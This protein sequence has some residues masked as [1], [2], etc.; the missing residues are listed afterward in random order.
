MVDCKGA[1][2]NKP[3]DNITTHLNVQT[4]YKYISINLYA[5]SHS[6]LKGEHCVLPHLITRDGKVHILYSR[7]TDTSV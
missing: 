1:K 3:D 2:Q 4:L 5:M 6:I 7:S